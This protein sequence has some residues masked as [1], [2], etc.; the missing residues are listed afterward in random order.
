[1]KILATLFFGLYSCLVFSQDSILLSA[2]Q[3]NL[4]ETR[5][6]KKLLHIE[7]NWIGIKG[8][9]ITDAKFFLSGDN[10]NPKAELEATLF[11]FQKPAEDFARTIKNTKK[12]DIVDHSEHPICRFPARLTFLQKNLSE[13]KTYWD[14]LPKVNCSFLNIYLNAIDAKSV[15]FVFSS[16]Y[17]D[18]PGSAFGHTFFRINRKSNE[19]HQELLDFGVGYAAQVSVNNPVLYAVLGLVGGFRGIWTNL[20]YYYKVREYN[21][22]EA[23][24]LW[25]YDLNLKP[26]EV[27]MLSYHLWE[28]GSTSYT[29]YFF[30]QNCAFHM[31]TVLEAAAPRLNLIDHVPFWYVIPADSMKSLFHEKELVSSVTFRPSIR[32][33]FSQRFKTLDKKSVSDIKDF[34]KT[35]EFNPDKGSRTDAEYAAYLDTALDLI[36]LKYPNLTKEKNEKMFALK[37][38]VLSA[39]SMIN[40]ISPT[41]EI[42]T[43]MDERPDFSH[44]SSRFNLGTVGTIKK[45]FNFGYRFALHDLLDNSV[46]MP[47][48]SQLEFFN[49]QFKRED[50]KVYLENFNLF[51]VLNINTLNFYEKKISWGLKL[52]TRR[53]RLAPAVEDFYSTG[54]EVQAGYAVGLNDSERPWTLWTMFRT[55]LSYAGKEK[56]DQYGYGALG[57]QVGLLKRF[58]YNHALLVQYEKMFPNKLDAFER[59]EADFRSSLTKDFSVGLGLSKRKFKLEAFV[60]F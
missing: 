49:L 5:Q 31:L 13:H 26:E 37:E 47:E 45:D 23:R 11:A 30:T 27:E 32:R 28:V 22:H 40:T 44:G 12:E 25:S 58:S 20:P 46:G 43:T 7:R 18:S 54:V 16:Y 6:W 56:N 24:D 14:S 17:S 35:F 42:A 3:K 29:Y 51:K 36:N 19:S 15:S 21:D 50:K 53:M 4:S 60:Y 52:G 1:M 57:Y 41:V 10:N 8:S 33:V 2:Q 9:Q 48:N 39:R 38:K 59:I 34:A 55:D